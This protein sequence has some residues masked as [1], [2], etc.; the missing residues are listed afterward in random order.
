MA[1]LPLITGVRIEQERDIVPNCV[2]FGKTLLSS[3]NDS[4]SEMCLQQ[5]R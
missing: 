3:G 1:R 5:R 4:A 2:R